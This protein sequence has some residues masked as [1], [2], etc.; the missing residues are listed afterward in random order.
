MDLIN[1]VPEVNT[2]LQATW[3]LTTI[4]YSPYLIKN[5]LLVNKLKELTVPNIYSKP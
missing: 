2:T 5:I 1:L 4:C 3:F